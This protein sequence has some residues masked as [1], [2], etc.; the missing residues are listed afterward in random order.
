[1][2]SWAR[3]EISATLKADVRK[4]FLF[5]S[6]SVGSLC[7]S[8]AW[9][10]QEDPG[11]TP[12]L[13]LILQGLLQQD[14]PAG[15]IGTSWLKSQDTLGLKHPIARPDVGVSQAAYLLVSLYTGI[16]QR[17]PRREIQI[18]GET[19]ERLRGILGPWEACDCR[20][21]RNRRMKTES[22]G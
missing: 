17:K 1:M 18:R 7:P 14:A 6:F 12:G 8:P 22:I 13:S 16:K 20:I 21:A 11:A 4:P 19:E 3:G 10:C 15:E 9:G 5:L 2:E